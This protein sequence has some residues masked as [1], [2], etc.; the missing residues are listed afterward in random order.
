MQLEIIQK[1]FLATGKISPKDA[2]VMDPLNFVLVLLEQVINIIPEFF[3]L[4]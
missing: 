4:K 2:F 1:A 3:Q